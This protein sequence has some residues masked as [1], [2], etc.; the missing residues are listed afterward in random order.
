MGDEE[1]RHKDR[2]TYLKDLQDAIDEFEDALLWRYE[3]D[4]YHLTHVW[5]TH[6]EEPKATTPTRDEYLTARDYASAWAAEARDEMSNAV[7]DYGSHDLDK[8][9][10]AFLDLQHAARL[11]GEERAPGDASGL[12]GIATDLNT[13]CDYAWAGA[14]GEAFK[15]KFGHSA[16][17]TLDNQKSIATNLYIMYSA[18][19]CVID[20]VRRNTINA[21]KGAATALRETE[22]SGEE[23]DL[24][25]FIAMATIPIGIGPIADGVIAATE[26]V[27]GLIDS[28]NPDQQFSNDIKSVMKTLK[29]QL[30]KAGTDANDAEDDLLIKVVKLQQDIEDVK[31]EDL[32]LY[33]FTG[34]EYSPNGITGGFEVT[35]DN[36]YDLAKLCLDASKGYEQVITSLVSADGGDGQ[37]RGEDYVRTSADKELIDTKDALVSFAKTTC[38]RYYEAADRLHETARTYFGVEADSEDAFKGLEEDP[39]LNGSDQE[40]KGGSV[41]KHVKK[42]NRDDIED[43]TDS[44]NTDPPYV[45]G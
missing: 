4:L 44:V 35:A 42:S 8:L 10:S 21:F 2:D 32:E 28:K 14:S 33:N 17:T 38:A 12:P 3:E 20:S 15:D 34:G 5:T 29:H 18:R 6:G 22:D 26:A 19:A 9:E 36:I 30:K 13:Q 24:W 23:T 11:L 40:G 25:F 45:H 16:E 43:L 1:L 31:S 41:D 7:A 27:A 37:L 39:D